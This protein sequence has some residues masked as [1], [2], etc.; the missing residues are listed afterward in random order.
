[1]V[2]VGDAYI[3]GLGGLAEDAYEAMLWYKMA[4][5]RG[6]EVRSGSLRPREPV[7]LDETPSP[8]QRG[9]THPPLK[10]TQ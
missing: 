2:M 7:D 10:R 4:A 5:D 8:A 9:H 1:M 3:Q 6:S